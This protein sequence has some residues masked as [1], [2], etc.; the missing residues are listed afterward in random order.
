MVLL[1]NKPYNV[2][3]Q[4]TDEENRPSLANFVT[5]KGVYPAGRLDRDSEGLVILT[6]DGD[7][8]HRISDPRH[9]LPKTYWV[10]VEGVPDE[11]ALAALRNGVMLKDGK[12]APADARLIPEPDLWPRDPPIRQRAHIPTAWLELTITEGRNRQVR[13]MTAAAG[14][15]TLR[16]VRVKVGPWSLDGLAPGE[17]REAQIPDQW[18]TMR[19]HDLD[20]PRH[21]RR[22]HPAGKPLP[23]GG[24]GSRRPNRD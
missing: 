3:C 10:Q 9:K 13:R 7:L 22:R 12:T 11:G 23:G 14:H 5:V 18:A 4:F 8:Q 19:A 16:L 1:I 21:R 15:P 2:L 20:T 24:R 17:S 6:D